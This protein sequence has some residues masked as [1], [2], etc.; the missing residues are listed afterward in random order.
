M[1]RYRLV[2]MLVLFGVLPVVAVFFLTL[3]YLGEPEPEPTQAEVEPVVEEGPP[4]EPPEMRRVLVAS[5][6]LPVGTLLGEE[7]LTELEVDSAALAK[8]HI[9]V[10]EEAADHPLRGYVVREAV[11]DGAPLT[12]SAVVGPNQSGFLAAVLRPGMRAV[13]IRVGPA[14]GHAGLVDPGDRVDVILSAELAF[15]GRDRSVFAT[16]IVEDARVVAIDRRVESGAGS[17]AGGEEAEA[18]RERTEVTTA[19]LEVTPAQGERLVLGR[20]GRCAL[21]GGPLSRDPRGPDRERSTVQYIGGAEGDAAAAGGALRFGATAAARAE[22]ERPFGA[23]TD[24]RGGAGT[25]GCEGGR[26]DDAGYGADLP[27][28]RARRRSRVRAPVIRVP[29]GCPAGAL[30]RNRALAL[31]KPVP[32][33]RGPAAA[34][35]DRTSDRHRVA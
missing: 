6:A 32:S 9:L 12:R 34:G 33:S 1:H 21:A 16:T 5:R 14:T 7:D 27:R 23:Q 2:I 24:H 4:P 26:R 19:T 35:K 20:A 11:E 17:P 25:A 22:A 15:D 30:I 3:S 18:G 10:P 28:Q 13:T 31:P 8:E 29:T